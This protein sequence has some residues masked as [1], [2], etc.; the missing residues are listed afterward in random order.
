MHQERI[1][2]TKNHAHLSISCLSLEKS[3]PF[4]LVHKIFLIG[5]NMFKDLSWIIFLVYKPIQEW[6]AHFSTKDANIIWQWFSK[7]CNLSCPIQTCFKKG[8]GFKKDVQK[9]FVSS[10]ISQSC[11]LVSLQQFFTEKCRIPILMQQNSR[12]FEFF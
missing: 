5:Q 6:C 10:K 8:L 1:W 7:K 11:S 2:S 9:L 3:K 12:I 4:P